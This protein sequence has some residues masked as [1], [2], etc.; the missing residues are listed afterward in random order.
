ML[1]NLQKLL[2]LAQVQP[3]S[4]SLTAYQQFARSIINRM[5]NFSIWTII[6]FGTLI[7]MF[8]LLVVLYEIYRSNK[9]KEDL[10]NLAWRKFDTRAE[11]L[12]LNQGAIELLKRIIEESGLQD[13]STMIKSPHVFEK[14]I[15]AYYDIKKIKTI[16]DSRLEKI[17]DLRR[18]LSFLPLSKDIAITST[19]QFEVGEKCAV[20]IPESG[21]ATHKGM[22]LI[23]D[24]DERYWSISN[25]PGPPVPEKTWILVN[26]VRSGDAEYIFRAQVVKETDKSIILTHTS[27][28]NRA[29]QRNWV[30]IDVSIPVEVTQ[31]IG[32]GIGDIF[33]GKI[34]D[35]SGGGFGMALP[36]KLQ[37]NT[38]LLLNFELPGHGAIS[39]LPAKVVRVAGKYNND[40]L[41]TVHSVAFDGDIHLI[42]E[43]IIQY[44]FEKQRQSAQSLMK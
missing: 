37:K 24:V 26:F 39:D 4:D 31:I 16:S 19:R 7:V 12:K 14:T 6:I 30:R 20:Q 9:T 27:K 11:F 25:L 13:P 17:R 2:F 34:I 41:R 32:N 3:A 44:V 33:S 18:M 21:P 36:V 15:G 23:D 42:Q 5:T 43:Q 29:Q 22:C 40:P 35:M 28:M 38:R 1:L 10:R 8:I